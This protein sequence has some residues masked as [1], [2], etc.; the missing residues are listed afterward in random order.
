MPSFGFTLTAFDGPARRGEL[1]TPHGVVQT[2]AFMPVGT[3]GAVKGLTHRDLDDVGAEIILGNT[4]HLYLRPGDRLIARAGGLHRFIGWERP[5]LTDSGGYQIFSLADRRR[6]S[7]GGAEFRSHLDGSLHLLTPETAVDI[8]LQLG[9]DIAMV[10]DECI[11]TPADPAV[12]RAAMERSVRWARRSRARWLQIN[13][14]SNVDG[15]THDVVVT[16]RGQAQFGIVQGA[17]DPAL[18]T[19]SVQATVEI[20]FDAYA[21]GGLSV[22]ESP[23][24]MYELVA[25]TAPQLPAER[26]RY[27]MGTGLPD[28]LIECVARG[29][30]MFDCVLP[31]RNARN[32]QLITRDGVLV[33]KNACYA[34]DQTPP[35]PLCGCYTC[36][37][38]SRAYLRHLFVSGEMTAATLNSLHNLYFYLDTMRRI[39]EAIV[40]G[41]F[42]KLRR[43]FRQT[44]RRRPQ[45]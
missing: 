13:D 17:T 26:P 1:R 25:H 9:S 20:G 16:N 28:D 7:E 27:L 11:A 36:R 35:D 8:Q 34:E 31:T 6:I 12:A 39:R 45:H 4:Y 41:T 43:E 30:D 42:E 10:L 29:I 37:H 18:R 21:I 3:R 15:S 22:G 44:F 38:F 19:E 32:G 14:G 33:I 40:F 2:P 24:V 23:D 5:I